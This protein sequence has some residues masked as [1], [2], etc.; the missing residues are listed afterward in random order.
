MKEK[1]FEYIRHFNKSEENKVI[2]R[3]WY[4]P[5]AYGQA[6]IGIYIHNDDIYVGV[7]RLSTKDKDYVKKTGIKV[8]RTKYIPLMEYFSSK[9]KYQKVVI[10]VLAEAL[11]SYTKKC[12]SIK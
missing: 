11:T 10:D 4:Y 5:P 8:M 2:N 12:K 1:G 9:D 7:A 6:T 3:H